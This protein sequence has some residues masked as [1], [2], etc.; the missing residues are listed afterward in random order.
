MNEYFVMINTKFDYG[1]I[2]LHPDQPW[3]TGRYI[4]K[5]PTKGTKCHLNITSPLTRKLTSDLISANIAD[6]CSVAMQREVTAL[7][8]DAQFFETTVAIRGRTMEGSYYLMHILPRISCIDYSRSKYILREDP[9]V[10]HSPASIGKNPEDVIHLSRIAIDSDAVGERDL[11][12]I[13]NGPFSYRP[14]AS[15]R[16]T[17]RL[18]AARLRGFEM[19]PL[20]TFEYDF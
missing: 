9:G 5:S 20:N 11:F 14:V 12:Y 4:S 6:V 10:D 17:D 16:L 3:Y 15:A 7:T 13:D 1:D 8:S 18:L 19:K 2:A